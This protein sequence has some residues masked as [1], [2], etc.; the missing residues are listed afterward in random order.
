MRTINR[1]LRALLASN[2]QSVHVILAFSFAIWVGSSSDVQAQ[3][4]I[5]TW[6]TNVGSF[7]D[8]APRQTFFH[9]VLEYMGLEPVNG[10]AK[11]LDVLILQEQESNNSSLQ[12][13]ADELNAITGTTDYVPW[14][15]SP[16][17]NGLQTGFVYNSA[18]V[19]SIHEDWRDTG[20][21]NTSRI[22]LRPV[23]Y[24]SSADIWIY[25]THYSAN[26]TQT[27]LIQR[28]EEAELIRQTSLQGQKAGIGNSG[29][30]FGSDFL[31][32]DAN[33]IYAGDFNQLSG[34]EEPTGNAEL[35]FE[36][37]YQIMQAGPNDSDDFGAFAEFEIFHDPNGVIPLGRSLWQRRSDRCDARSQRR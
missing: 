25:N 23:G 12:D 8:Y 7:G 5:A 21:R 17:A 22:Q 15:E 36:N 9:D 13:F 31:P 26:T 34:T 10:F 35:Y 6:N 32:A 1:E 2:Y 4:R 18:T 33:I 14:S 37:P 30:A 16:T 11:P 28:R 29:V 3:L 24:G 19:Q 27:D 20:L